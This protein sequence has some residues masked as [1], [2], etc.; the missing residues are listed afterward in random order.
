MYALNW[1]YTEPSVAS[2]FGAKLTVTEAT[3]ATPLP[4]HL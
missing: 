3:Q 4:G 2:C 1:N